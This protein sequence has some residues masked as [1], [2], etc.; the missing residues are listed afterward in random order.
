MSEDLFLFQSVP[1]TE[2]R[3]T[4]GAEGAY[5]VEASKLGRASS[6]MHAR[7][8][9]NINDPERKGSVT[10]RSYACSDLQSYE[11]PYRLIIAKIKKPYIPGVQG[12]PKT[13]QKDESTNDE[14]AANQVHHA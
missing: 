11:A 10:L 1:F 13:Y 4:E 8:G 14:G 2:L 6:Y 5:V 12:R 7:M 3:L 9:T